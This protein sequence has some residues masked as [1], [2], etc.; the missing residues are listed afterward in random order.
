MTA[1]SP[2][3][4]DVVTEDNMIDCVFIRFKTQNDPIVIEYDPGKF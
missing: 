3:N 4:I 2:V 1:S